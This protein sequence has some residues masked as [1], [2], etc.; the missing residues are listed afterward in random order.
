MIEEHEKRAA[1]LNKPSEEQVIWRYVTID[2]FIHLLTTQTLFFSPATYFKD[3]FEG[4]YGL[5]S[6]QAIH[7]D[8]GP[9]QFERDKNT[10]EFL[11]S[12]TYISCWHENN[13]E[14]DAMWQSYGDA[15]ALKSTFGKISNLLSWKEDEIRHS[16][17]INY[18]DYHS[19]EIDVS[20]SY[21]SYF[22]KRKSFSHEKEVRFLIQNYYR[23]QYNEYPKPSLGKNIVLDINEN[24][25]EII[26]SPLM[27]TY[28]T[29]S[30]TA[31]LNKYQINVHRYKSTLLNAP[32]W[33]Y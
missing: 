22:Y 31:L 16:G 23:Y 20:S 15:V 33:Q 7:R 5:I 27:P 28:I 17:R 13:D 1:I 3:P 25:D 30:L 24:I 29:D 21:I 8:Y 9:L 19:D 4:D 10:Y 12:H 6:K 32:L 2:K 11:K 26:F 18:I 14:S